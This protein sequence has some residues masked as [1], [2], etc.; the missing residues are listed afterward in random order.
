MQL[1][2]GTFGCAAI[3]RKKAEKYGN[4][5]SIFDAESVTAWDQYSD[6]P[7][8]SQTQLAEIM[9]IATFQI[10]LSVWGVIHNH[11]ADPAKFCLQDDCELVLHYFFAQ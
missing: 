4:I 11:L 10:A 9:Q 3:S 7:K 8:P 5:S 6:C 2:L 1:P